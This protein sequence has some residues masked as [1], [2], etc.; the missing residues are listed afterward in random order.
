M[1]QTGVLQCS[2]I[3]PFEHTDCAPM[4]LAADGAGDVVYLQVVVQMIQAQSELVDSYIIATET[5]AK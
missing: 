3:S 2:S 4:G 1:R 5:M